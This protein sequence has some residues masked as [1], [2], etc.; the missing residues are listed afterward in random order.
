MQ[1]R[2]RQADGRIFLAEQRCVP[3]IETSKGYANHETEMKMEEEGGRN[4][5]HLFLIIARTKIDSHNGLVACQ[6]VDMVTRIAGGG[7]MLM[8]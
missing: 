4:W 7:D 2:D 1:K 3:R 8:R 6:R 5:G